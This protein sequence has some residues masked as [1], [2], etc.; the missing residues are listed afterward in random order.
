MRQAI[1]HTLKSKLESGLPKISGIKVTPNLHKNLAE[2]REFVNELAT[3]GQKVFLGLHRHDVTVTGDPKIYFILDRLNPTRHDQ[4]HPGIVDRADIQAEMIRDLQASKTSVIILDHI[5]SDQV[6]N[7]AKARRAAN[8]SESGA[9]V[10]D[11]FIH[12][13][14]TKIRTIGPYDVMQRRS[15][16][17][18]ISHQDDNP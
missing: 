6:L 14:Y 15:I 5:F 11:D 4:L 9:Q 3:P 18:N 7:A 16:T 8:L 17:R 10:L 2:L 1:R 13:N 12:S